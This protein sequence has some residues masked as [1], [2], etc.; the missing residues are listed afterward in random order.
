MPKNK[1]GIDL[2]FTQRHFFSKKN[3]AGFTL[4]ELLVVI[5]VIG[6]LA[7][8]SIVALN[9]ARIKTRDAKRTADLK[10]IATALELYYDKN[11]NYPAIFSGPGSTRCSAITSSPVNWLAP[12]LPTAPIDPLWK[13]SL[14]YSYQYCVRYSDGYDRQNYAIWA[15]LENNPGNA[16]PTVW[17]EGGPYRPAGYNYVI[18]TWHP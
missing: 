10:Q 13:G 9:I 12:Y 8:A 3:G 14:P 17:V 4:I 6:F 7:S 16:D 11:G 18:S 2:G 1:A 15:S 5:S